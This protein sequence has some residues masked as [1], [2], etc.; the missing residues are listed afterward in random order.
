MLSG[1]VTELVLLGKVYY[2]GQL[3]VTSKV[4]MDY[5]PFFIRIL[6]WSA[7]GKVLSWAIESTLL[8]AIG[9]LLQINN[10]FV[11]C[12]SGENIQ[13]ISVLNILYTYFSSSTLGGISI[14]KYSLQEKKTHPYNV[15]LE[16][17]QGYVVIFCLKQS[18]L[19]EST[20]QSPAWKENPPSSF[21][22][23]LHKFS[24]SKSYWHS[25]VQRKSMK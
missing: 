9:L 19:L 15:C 1:R 10:S 16:I 5:K 22:I 20:K 6:I 13:T 7:R 18:Y 23:F 3:E 21:L 4:Q 17:S 24:A 11:S 12:S 8:G 2:L 14:I 25:S